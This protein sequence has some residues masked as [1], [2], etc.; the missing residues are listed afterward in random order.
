[1]TTVVFDGGGGEMELMALIVVVY[2][3]VGGLCQQRSLS[4]EAVMEWI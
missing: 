1:L 3:G 4:T 2:G